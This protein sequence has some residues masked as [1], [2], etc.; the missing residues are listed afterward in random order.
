MAEVDTISGT[1]PIS[2]ASCE[3]LLLD[4]MKIREKEY[5]YI[6]LANSTILTLAGD[7]MAKKCASTSTMSVM[8]IPHLLAE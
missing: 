3:G 5:V 2:V 4:V 1:E 6:L 7:L 8:T